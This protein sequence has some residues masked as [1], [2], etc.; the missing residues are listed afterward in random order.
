MRVTSSFRDFVLDQLAELR[1]LR[2]R[3]MFGGVGL[4]AEDTFFGLI[5]ADTLYLK[6]DDSNRDQYTRAGSRAFQPYAGRPMTMSYFNVPA[7][8]IDD[9]KTLTAW[10]AQSVAVAAANQ[11]PKPVRKRR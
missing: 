4:Y 11:K 9:T 3:P 7:S 1:G 6:V 8:V 10:A 2:A 5:A